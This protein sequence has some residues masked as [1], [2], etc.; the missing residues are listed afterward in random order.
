MSKQYELILTEQRDAVLLITLNRPDRMNAWTPAMSAEMSDAIEAANADD[1]IGAIVVTGAGRG[2]CAGADI[3]AVFEK[4]LEESADKE[5]E[6]PQ[7]GDWVALCRR[8]KPLIAAVNGPSIGVGLTMIL[9]FDQIVASS[10]AKLSA[11]FVKMGLVT[12][13]ASSHYLISRCGW[14][15]GSWLALSGTTI[16]GDEAAQLGLVDRAVEPERVLEV[17]MDMATELSGN[18]PAQLR[19]V[20][21]LLTANAVETDLNLI[22]QREHD[23]LE[24]SY[25][26]PDHAEAIAAFMEKRPPVFR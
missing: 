3:G 8:S 13:L 4:N 5:P 17:A 11:R 6:K 14:G 19:F 24:K 16:L 9:P 1:S 21:E 7:V 20:K 26:T 23:L 15:A 25:K 22:Q 2:F 12:E 10:T 18:P